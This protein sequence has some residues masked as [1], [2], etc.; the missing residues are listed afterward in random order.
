MDWVSHVLRDYMNG[1][2]FSNSN[3]ISV[4]TLTKVIFMAKRRMNTQFQLDN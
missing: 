1:V 2:C 4:P 3:C